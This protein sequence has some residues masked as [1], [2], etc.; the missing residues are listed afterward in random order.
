MIKQE[1]HEACALEWVKA[2]YRLTQRQINETI[3]LIEVHPGMPTSEYAASELTCLE[4][5]LDDERLLLQRS[6]LALTL[7][8]TDI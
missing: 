6:K 7:E 3:Y 2:L 8:T 4:S 5:I 1:C